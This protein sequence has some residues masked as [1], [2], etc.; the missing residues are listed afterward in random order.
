MKTNK[1]YTKRFKV[2]KNGKIIGRHKGQNHFNAKG[3]GNAVRRKRGA[4]SF[5]MTNKNRGRYLNNA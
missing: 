1:S 3:S 2:T 4:V 5:V